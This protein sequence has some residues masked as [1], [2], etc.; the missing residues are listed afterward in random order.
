MTDEKKGAAPPPQPLRFPLSLASVS[1]ALCFVSAGY[2]GTTGESWRGIFDA[3]EV[4][5]PWIEQVVLD[6]PVALP[7]GLIAT[8]I[9]LLF[10]TRVRV[11]SERVNQS[12]SSV[13]GVSAVGAAIMACLF[14]YANVLVIESMQKAIQQ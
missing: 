14:V 8:G 4:T 7:L 10:M 9:G 11:Q 2:M 12:L 5:L 3:M 6:N 13:C 1:S